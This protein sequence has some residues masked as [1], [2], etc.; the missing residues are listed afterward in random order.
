MH[1]GYRTL[2]FETA[3]ETLLQS[4]MPGRVFAAPHALMRAYVIEFVSFDEAIYANTIIE[5]NMP[6]TYPY[7][8]LRHLA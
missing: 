1:Q 5:R 8:H 2:E 7:T 3:V 4:L 6:E